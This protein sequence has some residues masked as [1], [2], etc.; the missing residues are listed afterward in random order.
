MKFEEI[1]I[2]PL[3]L[4]AVRDLKF[5]EMTFIQESVL[6]SAL[7]GKD[8]IGQSPTGS[9]KTVAFSIPLIQKV[10]KGKGVQTLVLS[11]TRELALQITDMIKDMSRYK[12]VNVVTVYGGQPIKV[13]F[14][15]LRK[16]EIVVG[17]PGRVLDH[18][19]RGTLDLSGVR[20]LVLDEADRMLDMGFI[21]DITAIIR[22]APRNRQT[23]LFGATIPDEIRK[24]AERFMK[25][26]EIFRSGNGIEEPK[27]EQTYIEV[28][29][30]EKFQ[31]L[32]ALLEREDPFSAIIFTNTQIMA[33]VLSK[34]L[35][36]N[37]INAWAIHG[38]LTQSRRER[39]MG[40]FR[41]GDF[42]ILVATDVASRGL[43]ITGVSHIFNYDIPSS[44]DDYTHRIGRT[45]RAGKTGR[46]I[47]I[48]SPDGHDN[49]RRIH[50]D[51]KDVKPEVFGGFDSGNYPRIRFSMGRSGFRKNVRRFGNG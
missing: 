25:N 32:L 19:R 16:A 36:K 15:G 13:Q 6:P 7:D 40:R 20:I 29:K 51:H 5:K 1:D 45:A 8:V 17:T 49:M 42:P 2:N 11:P 10:E 35:Y 24:L 37:R 22:H 33:D 12:K 30:N 26:P 50:A 44:A 38:R 4:E 46:A 9:G 18:L 27:V 14:V 34:N 47:C 23:L 31:M 48:L 3:I 43:D 41:K 28:R 21:R 39:I